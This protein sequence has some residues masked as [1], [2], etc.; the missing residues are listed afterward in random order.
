[1]YYAKSKREKYSICNLCRETKA[2]SW[3]HVPPK[4]A[5]EL[6]TVKMNTIFNIMT[7]GAEQP[8]LRESQNGM[9]YRTICSD[10][11]SLLGSAYDIEMNNFATDIGSYLASSIELP[12]TINHKLKPQRLMKAILG[13]LVAAKV[14]IENTEFDRLAREYVL[15][16]SAEFPEDLS[17]FYWIYP[18]DC[19]VTIR[20]FGMFVPRGTFQKPT[21]FQTLK[22]FPLA[23]LCCSEPEYANLPKLSD[24]RGAG[25]D[26]EIE[27]KINLKRVEHP[28][29]PEA[30]SDKEN[31]VLFMG[32]SGAGSVH[33]IPKA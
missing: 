11:N 12:E 27:I 31:N 33:A 8:K 20:D 7:A 32:Q 4:G 18:H 1:M 22:Y 6:T 17:L 5:I 25:L 29:W 19:S 10:C 28:Y 9:R 26:E 30:P 13:H 23:Y 16:K 14:D 21:I 15:D 2:L 3:D 24:Y